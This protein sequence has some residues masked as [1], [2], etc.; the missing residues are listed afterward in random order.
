MHIEKLPSGSYRIIQKYN[1]KKYSVTVKHK[2]TQ[3]EAT[4]L[5]AELLQDAKASNGTFKQYAKEYIENRRN[6]LSPSS[7]RTYETMITL[8]SDEFNNT[9]LYD[10]DQELVQ[11]E[12]NEYSKT[13]AP[14]TT[15]SMHGFIASVLGVNRPSF[16]L[17]TT[18]PKSEAK[19]SYLPSESDIRAI[20]N[21]A[22]D[23]ECSIG[24]QL[25]V[26]GLRRGEVC[27][28]TMDS[29]NGNELTVSKTLVYNKG[30]IVKDT[31]K[32]DESFRTIMLPDKLVKEINEK[33]SFFDLSPKKLNEHLHMYQDQLGI[34]RF[35][36]HDLRHY[37]ASYCHSNGICDADIMA[38]GGWKS[39]HVMKRIYRDA[40]E[41][42]QKK[43]A[44]K[45]AN[46]IL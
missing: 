28:L 19:K 40:M 5:V 41:E 11:R 2:P 33:G 18:L 46:S 15:R 21:A 45:I 9:N 23:S 34:P 8:L 44:L 7:V 36:F 16:H 14:K 32:T 12:I 6:V 27:A 31:P 30:W 38:M 3:K 4:L 20:L 24:F 13:H 25:G 42:S 35:R 43:S 22:K 10:I 26:L 1:K 17:A 29:L 39:D 37:F